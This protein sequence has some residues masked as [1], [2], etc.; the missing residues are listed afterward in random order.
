MT[1]VFDFCPDRTIPITFFNVPRSLHDSQVA[2]WGRVC[3]K[4]GAV[5]D[6]TGGKCTVD[7]AFR[8]VNR[9]F[10]I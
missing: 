2:H 9:P 3:V 10:L 1:S 7:S 4:L 5:Y 6:E 8:K